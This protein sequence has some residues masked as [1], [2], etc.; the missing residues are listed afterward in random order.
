[1]NL[2]PGHGTVHGDRVTG[3]VLFDAV[4]GRRRPPGVVLGL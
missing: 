3:D 4:V 1:M 2:L